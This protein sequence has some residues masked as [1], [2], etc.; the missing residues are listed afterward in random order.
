MEFSIVI[1][2]YNTAAYLEACVQSVTCSPFL[3][4]EILLIDD[5]STDGVCPALCDQLAA[6]QPERIRVIH[7]KN[8]GLGGARNTGI[9]AA[10]GTY[11]LFLDSDDT[12]TPDALPVLAQASQSG[13]DVITF[14]TQNIS[15]SGVLLNL[16]R[17]SV[18][19][20]LTV[21]LAQCPHLLLDFPS[22]CARLWRRELFCRTGIRF[23]DHLRY[24]DLHT[25]GKLLL[26]AHSIL[27]LQEAP[28]LYLQREGSII[29]G[30][31]PSCNAD[32]T[33]ALDS[34][35]D[36]FRRQ[37]KLDQ[38]RPYLE[39]MVLL[40]IYDASYRTLRLD[41]KSPVLKQLQVY[42]KEHVSHYTSCPTYGNLL[43]SQ[44]ITLWFLQH[45]CYR[46]PAWI[47]AGKDWLGKQR[48]PKV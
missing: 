26:E 38:Y 14:H 17:H 28:Y 37:G 7:Q 4:Y 13:A 2:V 46:V 31:D 45:G 41:C 1:P 30:K 43:R 33:V 25:T 47:F 27:G 29:R 44:R 34:I 10:S 39:G 24:E 32:V 5:G 16:Q 9:E 21:T 20:D 15:E 22:A 23:P 36:W 3:D 40:H 12:L 19:V 42:L 18:P 8:R 35:W 48:R 6:Q 11:L